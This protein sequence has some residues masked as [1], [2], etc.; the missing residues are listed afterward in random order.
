MPYEF[1]NTE[2]KEIEE[3]LMSYKDLDKFA[4][5]NPHLEKR[6]S[7]TATTFKK[8]NTQQDKRRT[9]LTKIKEVFSNN[10]SRSQ[11]HPSNPI[12][13]TIKFTLLNCQRQ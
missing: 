7:A 10:G 4:E 3:H 5:D 2:T 6:I 8:I 1:Y 11:T 13:F 12:Q 9:Y